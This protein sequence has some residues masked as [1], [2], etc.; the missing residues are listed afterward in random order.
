MFWPP[1]EHLLDWQPFS[2]TTGSR[3]AAQVVQH[4]GFPLRRI[5][6][7]S[8]PTALPGDTPLTIC[9]CAAFFLPPG[10]HLADRQPVSGAAGSEGAAQGI[11]RGSPNMCTCQAAGRRGRQRQR[12]WQRQGV[13]GVACLF[14]R[15][16]ASGTGSS[17]VAE[18][19]VI[20]LGA[21]AVAMQLS[22]V[23]SGNC[24]G[25]A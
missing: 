5:H 22:A 18:A 20:A 23:T 13:K 9:Q 8:P 3:G 1:G 19:T 25:K 16:I 2:G 12:Q 17:W 14:G 4:L 11:L 7:H 10:E 15:F 24:A 21:V 6:A